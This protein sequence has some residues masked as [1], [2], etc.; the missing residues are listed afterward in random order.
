MINIISRPSKDENY[1]DI[2]KTVSKRNTCLRRL[3]GAII[4]KDDTMI[5]SGYVGAPK[6]EDN[7]TD[8][9]YCLRKELGIPS[10]Q[11]HEICRS[12]H[13]E[14]N[15]IINAASK[16]IAIDKAKLYIYSVPRSLEYYPSDQSP[17]E[18]YMPCYRC[19]KMIIN[20]GLE[21]II[22]LANDKIQKFSID[23]LRILLREEEKK[24]K[25]NFLDYIK[26]LKN[27]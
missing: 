10:G 2:A 7:C 18:L 23:D 1:L 21:E 4:V 17:T 3:V 9:G 13:A 8:L 22:V 25:E 24:L 14:E 5:S 6:K 26:K 11:F 16:G 20:A 15:A 19:K 12:V 27:G